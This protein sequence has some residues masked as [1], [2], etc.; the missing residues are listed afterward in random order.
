M[1]YIVLHR[2]R[3]V[4]SPSIGVGNL[5]LSQVRYIETRL[6]TFAGLQG[7]VSDEIQLDDAMLDAFLR[8]LAKHTNLENDS[9]RMLHRGAVVHLLALASCLDPS[10]DATASLFPSDWVLEAIELASKNM[11]K[12]CPSRELPQTGGGPEAS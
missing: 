7:P 3:E 9:V 8:R 11:I 1:G 2:N 6:D 10:F 12:H 5:F 4:W